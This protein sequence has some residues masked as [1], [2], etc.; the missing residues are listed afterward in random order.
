MD[1]RL[2]GKLEVA[3]NLL[4]QGIS[5]EIVIACTG[6]TEAQLKE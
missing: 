3:R 2:E 5:L 1:G 6:F 4:K